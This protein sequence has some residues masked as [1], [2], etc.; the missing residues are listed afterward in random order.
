MP[1]SS[2]RRLPVTLIPRCE[3]SKEDQTKAL[4]ITADRE[5]SSTLAGTLAVEGVAMELARSPER[6]WESLGRQAFGLVLADLDLG[7]PVMGLLAFLRK[8]QPR[9]PFLALADARNRSAGIHA[10]RLGAISYS[11]KPVLPEEVTLLVGSALRQQHLAFRLEEC[12]NEGLGLQRLLVRQRTELHARELE[13]ADR[14]TSAL[15]HRE[16]QSHDHVERVGRVAATLGGELGWEAEALDDLRTAGALHDVGMI[17]LPDDVL[18]KQGRLTATEYRLVQGHPEMG[19]AI[20]GESRI[21]FLQTAREIALG[22]HERWDG[23]GYPHGLAGEEI[24]LSARIVA[25]ADVYDALNHSRV[26]RPAVEES[27]ALVFLASQRGKGFDPEVLDCFMDVLPQVRGIHAE[28]GR[29][30]APGG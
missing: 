5:V 24:P 25:L 20:L 10:L 6:A 22:H 15:E 8:T 21:P 4:L 23:T 13:V 14:L 30:C 27:E 9:L 29:R 26:Y 18:L 17:G 11:L 7:T 16:G 12:R 19:A 2:L 1:P 3:S 28:I